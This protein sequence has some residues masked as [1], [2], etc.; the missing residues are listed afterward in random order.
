MSVVNISDHSH[1]AYTKVLFWS[2]FPQITLHV[3][4]CDSED[5]VEKCVLLNHDLGKSHLLG[6]T[7]T[8]SF[9]VEYNVRKQRFNVLGMG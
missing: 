1:L 9:F 8:V 6:A 4:V 2:K 7:S 3:L 5:Y